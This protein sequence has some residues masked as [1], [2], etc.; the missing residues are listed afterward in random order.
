M[1]SGIDYIGVGVGAVLVNDKGEIFIT[2]RGQKA[3]NE[4]GK[5]EI[6]GGSVEFGETLEKALK[7]EMREEVGVEIKL[8]ELLGVYDHIISDEKQ[9]WVSPTFMCKIIKGTPKILEPEKCEVIGWFTLENAQ[10]LDLSLI[11]KHDVKLLI[12]KFPDGK[13]IL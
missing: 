3:K 2:K 4:K 1:K 6:P 13:I 8:I 11:T 10:K 5:W 7:R 9:H 12:K